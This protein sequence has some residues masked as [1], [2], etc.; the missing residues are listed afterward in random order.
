LASVVLVQ[1][2][3]NPFAEPARVSYSLPL[4]ADS[5]VGGYSFEVDGQRTRGVIERRADARE[6]FEE[7]I[8][9]GRTASLLEQD[10]SSLFHQEI[11]NLPPGVE[12]QIEVDLDQPLHWL[13]SGGWEWRFP[14]VVGPR[15]LGGEGRVAD[16]DRVTVDV[17]TNPLAPRAALEMMITDALAVDAVPTSPSHTIGASRQ[18]DGTAVAL[19]V[20]GGVALDRDLV[21]RWPVALARPRTQLA[22]AR[23]EDH[24]VTGRAYGLLTVCPPAP[25][26]SAT[27]TPRDLVVLV[28]VSGSMGGEP[29]RQAAAVV[30]A[31]IDRLDA[32]DRLE[33]IAFSW[34]PV[35]WKKRAVKANARNK[36]AARAWLDALSAGGA[37]EMR[38]GILEALR[39]L[40]DDAQRQVVVVTDGLIGFEE[41][42]VD[43]VANRLPVG[44]RLHMI[45]VGSSVNRSLTG[46]AARAGRGKELIIGL[47]ED[48]AP[49]AGR[50]AAAT[51]SP[52]VVDLVLEGDVL[53]HAPVHTPDLYA[54]AP[55]SLAVSVPAEGGTLVLR[56]RTVEGTWVE[57]VEFGAT[58]SGSGAPALI[59]RFARE[60]V[61][62]AEIER[63][64]GGNAREV[65]ATVEALGLRFG[66]S[67][68][69]TS[70]VAVA[71]G[72]A[73][74]PSDPTRSVEMPHELPHGM[75]AQSVG[76]RA[77]LSIPGA[78]PA[79]FGGGAS[80]LVAMAPR[81][82]QRLAGALPFRSRSAS[83]AA[84]PPPASEAEPPAQ[85]HAQ[86][87]A[88]EVSDASEEDALLAES[89]LDDDPSGLD[90]LRA[91]G[92][93]LV[94][95]G[96]ESA[97]HRLGGRVVLIKDGR[98]TIELRVEAD[99]DWAIPT[100]FDVRGSD[101]AFMT[102]AV[103]ESRST[104]T[105]RVLAGRD[106]DRRTTDRRARWLIWTFTYRRSPP[107]TQPP[108]GAG[109]L[110]RRRG[111]A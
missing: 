67:T 85:E 59:R 104:R 9:E 11:G 47:G 2:F 5:A 81:V 32:S 22:L 36:K 13:T 6:R 87:I 56:G 76:L 100:H 75:S 98:A 12:I 43:A 19:Q 30:G 29:L 28:D 57:R 35:R 91:G 34:K 69:L 71:E 83:S 106:V 92:T 84:P 21:V 54:A 23:S 88:F 58:A 45:G 74:D 79:G 25:A 52:L 14:T 40:R 27:P 24:G 38:S 17:S 103:V 101:G 39:P 1:T 10:R 50:M 53:E 8:V 97:P 41:E 99:L 110:A 20:E 18:S 78:A 94:D 111:C 51:S 61:E 15:Y 55:A 102:V 33:L 93:L 63:A 90:E 65:D 64:S 3:R 77:S 89:D 96:A 68:R 62:D 4:P 16:A 95:E 72:V 49:F 44:S 60:R 7:A 70:W 31:M 105:G 107:V 109:S 48:P 46:P 86:L 66:I 80:P 82:K 37:T 108:S 26:S 73:V 42:I